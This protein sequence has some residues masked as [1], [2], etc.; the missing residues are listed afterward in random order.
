VSNRAEDAGA[1]RP[2]SAHRSFVLAAAS[3]ATLLAIV[4]V[5]LLGNIGGSFGTRAFSDI[6]E[7][8]VALGAAILCWRASRARSGS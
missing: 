8:L 4:A 1:T 2:V 5:W 3:A 7:T 6:V